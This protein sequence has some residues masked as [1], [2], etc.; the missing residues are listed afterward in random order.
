MGRFGSCP[1]VVMTIQ[2]SIAYCSA[3]NYKV[4]ETTQIKYASLWSTEPCEIVR[5][6]MYDST[7]MT[8]AQFR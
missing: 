4:L 2:H 6:E 8:F 3:E 5:V 1:D 7:G